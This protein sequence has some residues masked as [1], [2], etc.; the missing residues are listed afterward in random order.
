MPGPHEPKHD[1]NSFLEPFV[2]DLAKFWEGVELNVPS[3][4]C[5]KKIKCM[6]ACVACD[7]RAGRK[8][9]GFLGHGL[10]LLY[11]KVYW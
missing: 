11:E 5:R 4:G 8:I 9:C 6:L 10:F 7:L 1:L 3:K 2:S